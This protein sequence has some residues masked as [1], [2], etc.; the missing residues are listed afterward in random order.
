MFIE[1]ATHQITKAPEG[2]YVAASYGRR[3]TGKRKGGIHSGWVTQPAGRGNQAPAMDDAA[4]IALPLAPEGRHVYS[5]GGM[6]LVTKAPEGRHVAASYGRRETGK[7]KGGI[8]SGWVPQPIGRGN[9]APTM[10]GIIPKRESG[11]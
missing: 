10:A 5:T 7:R 11:F 4:K 1:Y 8:H 9:P 2:R 6:H 3:E